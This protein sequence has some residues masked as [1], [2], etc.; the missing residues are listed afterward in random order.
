M[1]YIGSLTSGPNHS[2]HEQEVAS[3]SPLLLRSQWQHANDV[4]DPLLM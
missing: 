3:L 2:S 4:S 1:G